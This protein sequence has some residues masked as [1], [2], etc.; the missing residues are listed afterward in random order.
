MGG[1]GFNLPPPPLAIMK[2]IIDWESA[3]VHIVHI[4]L[5]KCAKNLHFSSILPPKASLS[6]VPF[7]SKLKT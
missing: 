5:I 2:N 6:Q 1:G 3:N 4:D 7:T